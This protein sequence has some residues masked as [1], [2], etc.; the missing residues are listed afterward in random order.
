MKLTDFVGFNAEK[1]LSSRNRWLEKKKELE[2]ALAE[3]SEL[4]SHNDES[5][6]RGSGIS[7]PTQR[8]TSRILE[9]KE[10]IS[11]IDALEETYHKA[12]ES[13]DEEGQFLIK[14]FFE[15]KMEQWKFV[16]LAERKY[17]R[18][19][20][21]VYDKRREAINKIAEYVERGL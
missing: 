6:V 5:G 21:R 16:R 11:E 15:P 9:I 8:Q 2:M 12:I 10:K 13:L 20:S 1:F 19:R 7:D 14:G 4:P 17:G 3:I 18:K